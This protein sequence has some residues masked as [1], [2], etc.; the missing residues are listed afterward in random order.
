LTTIRVIKETKMEI[1]KKI[2]EVADTYVR[3][4]DPLKAGWSWGQA[5]LMYSLSLLDDALGQDKYLEYYKAYADHHYEKGIVVDQADTCAPV[6]VTNELYKKT[7]QEKYRDM[8]MKGIDYL[9]NEPRLFEDLINHNGHSRDAKDYPKSVWVD[10]VMMS[11]VFSSI[12]ARDYEDQ[13]L[14]G[15]ALTQP[16]QYAKYLQD[17]ETKLF[18]HS[19]WK[20]LNR[21]YPRHIFWGRGNGWVVAAYSIFLNYIEDQETKDILGQVSKALLDL[22]R[23]DYYWDTVVNKPGD[24][25]RESSATALIAAGWLNAVNHGHLGREYLKSAKKAVEALVANLQVSHV[26]KAW[27]AASGKAGYRKSDQLGT[28]MTE[29]S[30]WTIPMFIFPYRLKFGPYPGYKYVKKG[31]NVDYGLASLILAG[32]FYQQAEREN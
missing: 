7:G 6:L 15:F 20:I 28:Y 27:N 5:L 3:E 24:N 11:G 10:S 23:S 32:I 1:I 16:R 30:M 4:N 21:P 26:S 19:Y 13:D 17:K 14:R 22:Q 25:Y 29:T 12:A 9:K 8:T 18:H 2:I 31:G